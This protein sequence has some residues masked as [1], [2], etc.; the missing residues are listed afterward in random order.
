MRKSF[1]PYHAASIKVGKKRA[2]PNWRNVNPMRADRDTMDSMRTV[3]KD[4]RIMAFHPTVVHVSS[5]LGF[6][7]AILIHLLLRTS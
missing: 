5:A 4:S 3:E 2:H 1:F 6:S 7:N